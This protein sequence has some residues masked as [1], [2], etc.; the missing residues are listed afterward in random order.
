MINVF[1]RLRMGPLAVSNFKAPRSP[2]LALKFEK[3]FGD[4]GEMHTIWFNR[5]VG[6]VGYNYS[7]SLKG[8]AIRR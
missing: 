7:I 3:T 1:V 6:P 5:I 2:D 4:F 8:R